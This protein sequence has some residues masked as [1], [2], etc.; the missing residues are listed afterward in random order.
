M[1]GGTARRAQCQLNKGKELFRDNHDAEAVLA[2]LEAVRLKSGVSES[3]FPSQ[4]SV[5]SLGKREEAE[6]EYK[7]AVEAYKNVSRKMMIPKPYALGQSLCE[8][9]GN[10][11]RRYAS[12]RAATK[13]KEDNPDIY[14]NLGVAHTKLRAVRRCRSSESLEIDPELLSRAGWPG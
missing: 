14:Y 2:F 9:S 12:I 10:T 1:C 4:H 5:A 13:L 7:K 11:V 8:P 6:A 3:S